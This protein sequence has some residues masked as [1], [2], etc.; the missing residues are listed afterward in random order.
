MIKLENVIIYKS[1][2]YFMKDIRLMRNEEKDFL[3]RHHIDDFGA[4][5]NY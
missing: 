1:D 2:R 3:K 5:E 4:L